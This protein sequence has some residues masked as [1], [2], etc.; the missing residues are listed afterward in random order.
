MSLW[1]KAL[2]AERM[3]KI[4]RHLHCLSL[5][6]ISWLGLPCALSG[7]R[8]CSR[9]S[10]RPRYQTRVYS[11]ECGEG[12]RSKPKSAHLAD[13]PTLGWDIR[14]CRGDTLLLIPSGSRP[15]PLAGRAAAPHRIRRDHSFMELLFDEPVVPAQHSR[16]R[17]PSI[18][19]YAIW[20]TCSA[21]VLRSD[22]IVKPGAR[23]NSSR[24]GPTFLSPR[25]TGL[26]I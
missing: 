12:P 5:L 25:P 20:G 8:R 19:R 1:P 11:T 15:A 2:P 3:E 9:S 6:R 21:A 22:Q 18:Q 4:V 17:P 14:W 16:K 7:D 13:A 26:G 23:R 24:T 10:T